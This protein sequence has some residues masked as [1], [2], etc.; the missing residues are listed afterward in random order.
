[1]LFKLNGNLC[2]KKEEEMRSAHCK[3]HQDDQIKEDKMGGECR[4]HAKIEKCI[5]TEL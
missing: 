4:T 2:D 5:C 1:M 3:H